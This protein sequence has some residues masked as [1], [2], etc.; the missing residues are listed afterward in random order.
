MIPK[1]KAKATKSDRKRMTDRQVH[2][3]MTQ[4]DY[5]YLAELAHRRGYSVSA[6]LRRSIRKWRDLSQPSQ[7]QS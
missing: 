7:Q 2:V 3:W 6:L 4:D 5:E 1:M